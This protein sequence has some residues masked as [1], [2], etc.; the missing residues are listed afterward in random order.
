MG[1]GGIEK[2]TALFG[3][4]DFHF[5]GSLKLLSLP[6]ELPE[7]V[8]MHNLHGGYFDLRLLKSLSNQVPVILTL[9]DEWLLTGHCA[10]S[11]KCPRWMNGCGKC[12][13]LKIYQPVYRDATA[14][15]WNRKQKIY[16]QSKLFIATPSKWLFDRLQ[17]S[18]LHPY[19]AKIINNG[20]DIHL[21]APGDSSKARDDLQLPQD[22]KIILVAS[23]LLKENPFKDY[24]TIER[25]ITQLG[26]RPNPE[27]IILVTLGG[28]KGQEMLGSIPVYHFQFERDENRIVKSTRH[29]IYLFIRRI[30]IISRP[31]L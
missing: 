31:L 28:E 12:P 11:M 19:E 24:L 23:N 29:Q 3:W 21:F 18:M 15:N 10:A 22:A 20:V 13:D 2:Y 5:P 25:A 16:N 8:H 7:I 9:H 17:K 30:Q 27:N 14:F 1:L 6:P 26:T 4:E